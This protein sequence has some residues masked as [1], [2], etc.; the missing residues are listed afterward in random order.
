MTAPPA[1]RRTP[2]QASG[3]M[4]HSADVNTYAAL[5]WP[6]LQESLG[7]YQPLISDPVRLVGVDALPT[8]EILDVALVI[9]LEPHRFRVPLERQDVRRDAVEE[10]AVVRDHHR[11]GRE[12]DQCF[13]QR[14]KRIDIEIVGRLVEKQQI[15]T[16]LEQLRQVQPV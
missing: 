7:A 15:A 4:I 12:I 3:R 5:G 10:P 11:A 6:S 14:A 8:L 2:I 16:R 1:M 9:A 13:L